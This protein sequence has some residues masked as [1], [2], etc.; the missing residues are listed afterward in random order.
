MPG[1]TEGPNWIL[2]AGGAAVTALSYLIRRRQKHEFEDRLEERDGKSGK[3]QLAFHNDAFEPDYWETETSEA[4]PREDFVESVASNSVIIKSVRSGLATA[5]ALSY[6]SSPGLLGALHGDSEHDEQQTPSS[7]D[8]LDNDKNLRRTASAPP[9]DGRRC[10]QQGVHIGRTVRRDMLHRLRKQLKSRDEMILRMQVRI[11]EYEKSLSLSDGHVSK[12]EAHVEAT[13]G[14]LSDLS[15]EITLLRNELVDLV[16]F[17]EN[18]EDCNEAEDE[19]N[20]INH[21]LLELK[22]L[23]KVLDRLKEESTARESERQTLLQE[24]N[25][26]IEKVSHLEC[27]LNEQRMLI[28]EKEQVLDKTQEDLLEVKSWLQ[29]QVEE[30]ELLRDS[31]AKLEACLPDLISRRLSVRDLHSGDEIVSSTSTEGSDGSIHPPQDRGDPEFLEAAHEYGTEFPE[32]SAITDDVMVPVQQEFDQ[33]SS[34]FESNVNESKINLIEIAKAKRVEEAMARI[35]ELRQCNSHLSEASID[36]VCNEQ[37]I[38]VTALIRGLSEKLA[39]QEER[40]QQ[41]ALEVQQLST[42]FQLLTPI[43]AK[44]Q[45]TNNDLPLAG[46]SNSEELV[47]NHGHIKANPSLHPKHAAQGNGVGT[48]KS[49]QESDSSDG[50]TLSSNRKSPGF[51]LADDDYQ[52]QVGASGPL[53]SKI[54]RF[55]SKWDEKNGRRRKP[56]A[57]DYGNENDLEIITS[58]GNKILYRQERGDTDVPHYRQQSL[59]SFVESQD[60]SVPVPEEKNGYDSWAVQQKH[61]YPALEVE[62]AGTEAMPSAEEYSPP[63]RQVRSP[64]EKTETP[65]RNLFN[66]SNRYSITA[67]ESSLEEES[68]SERSFVDDHSPLSKMDST[69]ET[70]NLHEASV[71]LLLPDSPRSEIEDEDEDNTILPDWLDANEPEAN[72]LTGL[73]SNEPEANALTTNRSE[74]IIEPHR[75][76][77]VSEAG[78]EDR[79]SID[80]EMEEM[81]DGTLDDLVKIF[82]TTVT[83][84]S[85]PRSSSVLSQNSGSKRWL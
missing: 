14:V 13:G 66:A 56:F 21:T 39:V 8:N 7:L 72:T 4:R 34:K 48:P 82:S 24:H 36:E 19:S 3:A 27:A 46:Q 20:D 57:H 26:L 45:D 37:S 61:W 25:A 74:D 80:S 38:P 54:R 23:R 1:G 29:A 60:P 76:D 47:S 49:G 53:A 58:E 77:A 69:D 42:S 43:V 59:R 83:P 22:K 6:G 40:A 68:T 62:Q 44:L 64:R 65:R 79:N 63:V 16:K 18:V 84:S 15:K 5:P 12:L 30:T 81:L 17:D 31:K 67:A 73:D 71:E 50:S 51:T 55:S 32:D 2:L 9:E 28:S 11:F 35:A 10:S 33:L 78:S 41:T 52:F 70:P 85:T 75:Q